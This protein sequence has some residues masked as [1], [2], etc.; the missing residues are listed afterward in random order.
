MVCIC[1]AEFS[2]PIRASLS[3][4]QARLR[5]THIIT[6]QQSTH[7]PEYPSIAS[8]RIASSS[9]RARAPSRTLP[10][11]RFATIRSHPPCSLFAAARGV[12]SA[13]RTE[14]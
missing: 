9:G 2:D 1:H 12:G 14:H 5:T 10:P 6:P 13:R 8:H 4:A 3:S 7:G 11:P